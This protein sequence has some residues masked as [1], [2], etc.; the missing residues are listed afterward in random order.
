MKMLDWTFAAF[1]AVLMAAIVAL[2]VATE[3]WPH[4]WYE[5]ACCSGRDC[6][7]IPFDAVYETRDG[8][9]VNYTGKLGFRVNAFVPKGKE[10]HSQDG[11]FHG[12]ASETRFL[13]LYV[14]RNV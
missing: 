11:R 6:E 13:C 4:D 10:R 3:A 7:P 5:P 12:C 8:W 14:P 9:Q 2:V 1:A